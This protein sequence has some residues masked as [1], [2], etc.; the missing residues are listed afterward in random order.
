MR[1]IA[2]GILVFLGSGAMV[3]VFSIAA[4]GEFMR[5]ELGLNTLGYYAF[6]IIFVVSLPAAILAEVIRSRRRRK[7]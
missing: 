7:E 3:F 6:M 2:Y 1:P 4:V 5:G